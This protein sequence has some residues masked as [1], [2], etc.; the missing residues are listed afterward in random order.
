M[1]VVATEE[2]LDLELLYPIT[3]PRCTS[4]QVIKWGT[5]I[6]SFVM[7]SLNRQQQLPI[8]YLVASVAIL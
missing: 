7:D 8:E 2:L 3:L 5:H 6:L 1:A 4:W